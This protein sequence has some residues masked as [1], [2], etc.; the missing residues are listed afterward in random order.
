MDGEHQVTWKRKWKVTLVARRPV[1]PLDFG[2]VRKQSHEATGCYT[3]VDYVVF[4]AK[5][6]SYKPMKVRRKS[7]LFD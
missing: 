6:I 1:V 4:P 3:M 7:W 5:G 2:K